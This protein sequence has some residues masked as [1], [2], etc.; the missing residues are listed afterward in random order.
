[1]WDS[2]PRALSD[3]TLSRRARY[4]HFGTSPQ[5]TSVAKPARSEPAADPFN[6]DSAALQEERPQS[7]TAVGR[8]HAGHDRQPMVQRRM[9]P[10]PLPRFDRAGARFGRAVHERRDPRVDGR[11][12]AH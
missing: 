6:A 3:N 11:T 8:Q 5:P 12:H 4:D 9:L 2:N 1:G 10:G 7:P